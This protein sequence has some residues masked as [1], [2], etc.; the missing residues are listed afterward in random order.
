[1][2][3]TDARIKDF[4]KRKESQFPE[5]RRS[6]ARIYRGLLEDDDRL[7]D[8]VISRSYRFHRKHFLDLSHYKAL[9]GA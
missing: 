2:S 6:P 4:M 8:D 5:L 1:M 3:S 9:F 7:V